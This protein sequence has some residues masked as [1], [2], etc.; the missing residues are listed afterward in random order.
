MVC[1]VVVVISSR[2][3]AAKPEHH[4][5]ALCIPLVPSDVRQS[6]DQTSD[7]WRPVDSASR[8]RLLPPGLARNNC[9]PWF[10]VVVC[11]QCSAPVN[12]TYTISAR[13]CK[14]AVVGVVGHHT[15]DTLPDPLSPACQAL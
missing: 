1:A 14:F 5:D 9:F 10:V 8:S 4:S 3:D 2:G 13:S 11:G 15:L 6:R 12:R 7:D